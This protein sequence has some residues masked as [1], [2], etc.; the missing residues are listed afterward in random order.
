MR[1]FER[2]SLGILGI[3]LVIVIVACGSAST[4]TNSTGGGNSSANPTATSGNSSGSCGR[5]S[6]CVSPTAKPGGS[7]VSINTATATLHGKSVQ[8]LTNAQGLTLYY[9]TS[10]TASSV[11]SGSCA[12]AWPPLLSTS[13]PASATS[14]PG[15]LTLLT[16]TNGSQLEYN[17]HPLYTFSGDNAAGQMN[18]EGIGGVWFVVTTDLAT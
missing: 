18:G 13:V 11:C 7:T 2:F 10:D 6:A 4:T 5:Y 14:L 3:F 8:I 12:T 15:K 16:D 1:G 17:G 9:R